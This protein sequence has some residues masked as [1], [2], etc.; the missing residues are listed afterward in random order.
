MKRFVAVLVA[1]S[2]ILL[3]LEHLNLVD[4][5]GIVGLLVGLFAII[6]PDKAEEIYTKL[7]SGKLK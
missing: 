1:I 2:L 3:V 7:K 4:V 6:F 5:V